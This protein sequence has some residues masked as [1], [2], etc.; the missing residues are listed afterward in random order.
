MLKKE[1][2]KE[3]E[4]KFFQYLSHLLALRGYKLEQIVSQ[5]E[6]EIGT[7]YEILYKTKE[8]VDGEW[9]EFSE[10]DFIVRHCSISGV[11]WV[12]L[13]EMQN[14]KNDRRGIGVILH[15]FKQLSKEEKVAQSEYFARRLAEFNPA[16]V[17]QILENY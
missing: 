4:Q 13:S 7:V 17:S 16:L 8:L 14:Y 3:Y 15:E 1:T 2:K 9:R 10:T 6:N 12:W 5:E 11:N